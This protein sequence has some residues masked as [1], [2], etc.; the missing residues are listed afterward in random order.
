MFGGFVQCEL[1]SLSPEVQLI[2]T[3]TASEA[4]EQRS[5]DVDGELSALTGTSW[6]RADTAKLMLTT[7]G[8]LETQQLQYLPHRDRCA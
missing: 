5:I 6:Q 4:A 2:A 8:W 7:P 3:S 1:V